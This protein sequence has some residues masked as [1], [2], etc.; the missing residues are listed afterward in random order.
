MAESQHI[1]VEAIGGYVAL[2][3]GGAAALWALV[4]LMVWGFWDRMGK[5]AVKKLITEMHV[6]PEQTKQREAETQAVIIEWHNSPD[7]IKT[8]TEFVKGVIDNEVRR[9]DGVIHKDITTKVNVV[10]ADLSKKLDNVMTKFDK[11]QESQDKRDK[12][13]RE[14]N[15]QVLSKLARIEGQV[16]LMSGRKTSA[17]SFTDLPV[18]KKPSDD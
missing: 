12:D 15:T 18:Q 7:Q 8:R 13:N 5:P 9:D 3:V 1:N 14:F 4:M 10:E 2:V 11:F 6:E 16:Q 17:S